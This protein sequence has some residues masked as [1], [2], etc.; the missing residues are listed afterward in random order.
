MLDYAAGEAFSAQTGFLQQ[1]REVPVRLLRLTSHVRECGT[2]NSADAMITPAFTH[3][4]H[5]PAQ[6]ARLTDDGM[7]T[8]SWNCP[9]PFGF[10]HVAPQCP[11]HWRSVMHPFAAILVVTILVTAAAFCLALRYLEREDGASA[12]TERITDVFPRVS[13]VEAHRIMQQYRDCPAET[14]DIKR[15]AYWTL[16]DAGHITPSV[17]AER[18]TR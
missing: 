1:L 15:L 4:V 12:A 18:I 6:A 11:Q 9:A 8:V 17:R 5:T 3:P 2:D 13:V 14:C 7:C 16:V 10:V